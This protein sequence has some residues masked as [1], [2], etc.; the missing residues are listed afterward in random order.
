M[1][2]ISLS[3]VRLLQPL[4]VRPMKADRN[5]DGLDQNVQFW[6]LLVTL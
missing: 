3:Q 1:T 2:I 5:E 4:N 6:Q